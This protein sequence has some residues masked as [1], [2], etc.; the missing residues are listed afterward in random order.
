LALPSLT[1]QMLL[2]SLK[3]IVNLPQTSKPSQISD[4]NSK[5]H[6]PECPKKV[7]EIS[8]LEFELNPII[9]LDLLVQLL[10]FDHKRRPAALQA[11]NHPFVANIIHQKHA[12]TYDFYQ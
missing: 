8:C 6:H 9:A 11:L 10:D 1:E 4:K 5:T 3:S 12:G 2:R 7:L